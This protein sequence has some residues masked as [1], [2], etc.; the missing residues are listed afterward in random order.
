MGGS[1]SVSVAQK[2]A[3]PAVAT[4]KPFMGISQ[5]GWKSIGSAVSDSSKLFGDTLANRKLP[6]YSGFGSIPYSE[7]VAA[8]PLMN[9]NTASGYGNFPAGSVNQTPVNLQT[10]LPPRTILG[11]ANSPRGSGIKQQRI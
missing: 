5:E 2:A 4:P 7:P 11:M 10:A 3:A 1:T 9:F 8:S 6:D